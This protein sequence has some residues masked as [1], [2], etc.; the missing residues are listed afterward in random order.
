MATSLDHNY[1]PNL[2]PEQ[3]EYLISN[4]KDWSILHGLAVRP[5]TTFVMKDQDP[6]G[7]LA[8][9]APVTL[10]PSLFPRACFE[11]AKNIQ[12]AY[13]EL[14]ACIASDEKWLGEIVEEYE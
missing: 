4:L 9:T 3:A 2:S 1:P 8:V 14:Y 10:F 7:S 6:S 13:N 11:Q 5:P 12:K